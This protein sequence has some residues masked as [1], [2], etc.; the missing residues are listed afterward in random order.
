M[1]ELPY[2][3]RHFRELTAH[4]EA[5]CAWLAETEEGDFLRVLRGGSQDAQSL[6]LRLANR[7][8]TVFRTD[9]LAYDHIDLIAARDELVT[10]GLVEEVA[11]FRD[12]LLGLFTVAELKK[13]VPADAKPAAKSAKRPAWVAAA[14]DSEPARA[15]VMQHDLIEQLG[16]WEYG[17]LLYLYFGNAF[18]NLSEFVVHEIGHVRVEARPVETTRG[19]FANRAEADDGWLLECLKMGVWI[20]AEEQRDAAGALALWN[21]W[22][23]APRSLNEFTRKKESKMGNRVGRALERVKSVEG[24]ELALGIYAVSELPPARERRARVLKRLGRIEASRELAEAMCVD[25][26]PEEQQWAGDWLARLPATVGSGMGKRKGGSSGS[27]CREATRMLKAAPVLKVPAVVADGSSN[28]P[29]SIESRAAAALMTVG[30]RGVKVC[31]WHVENHLWSALFGLVLWEVIFDTGSAFSNPHQA[32]PEALWTPTFFAEREAEV[33]TALAAFT[34]ES[35][36]ARWQDKEGIW[37]PFTNW[38]PYVFEALSAC[39]AS[40]PLPVLREICRSMA[41]DPRTARRGFPDL[42]VLEERVGADGNTPVLSARGVEIKG[43]GDS[44]S[45]V[46]VVWLRRLNELGFVAE[47]LRVKPKAKDAR[48]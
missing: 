30:E 3:L 35:V 32:V 15:A 42:F 13:L 22:R 34:A 12:D 29:G 1:A 46:Q 45:D 25:G 7:V 37:S 28:P 8:P 48:P 17:K 21:E 38:S 39:L 11:E 10:A 20:A 18:Q 44:L 19:R 23:S 9:K 26:T 31:A 33:E 40:V 16:S 43:P 5:Q 27:K 6:F 2:Y 36:L 4:V 14:I 47:V 41:A 24:D